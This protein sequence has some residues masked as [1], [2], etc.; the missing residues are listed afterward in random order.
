MPWRVGDTVRER[1]S[2][3][4]NVDEGSEWKRRTAPWRG[5]GLVGLRSGGILRIGKGLGQW[6]EGVNVD[7][8]IQKYLCT[9]SRAKFAVT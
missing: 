8:Q 4:R 3:P 9:L 6:A 5:V 7:T 1:R 2:R